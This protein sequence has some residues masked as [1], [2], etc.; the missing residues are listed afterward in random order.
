M[1][2]PLVFCFPVL[3]AVFLLAADQPK[4]PP[5]PGAVTANAVASLKNGIEVYSLMGVGTKKTWDD[6]TNKMYILRFKSGKWTEG[7]AVPGVAGRLGASAV[8]A[9]GQIFLFGGYTVDGQGNE[10]VIA[11]VNSYIPSDQRWY[12]AADI[13]VPVEGAVIGMTHDR[14]IY[15][16]GGRSKNGPVNN[17]QVYDAEKNIW[18]QATAFPGTPVFGHAGAV[19]D[20]TIVYVDGAKKDATSGK[21]VASD[22]CWMGKIDHKDPNKV[23]WSKLPPHPGPGRFG[24]VAGAGERD[25]RVLFSGGTTAPHNFKGLDADGKPEELSPMTFAFELHGNRWETI[26]EDTYDVRAD[27]RG[28]LFTPL[29]PLILGGTLKNTAIS[30]RVLAVPK[31]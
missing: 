21:Y 24:I 14:Y 20:E 12:R 25:H 6:I 26:A 13:P 31:K 18:S 28:I 17:V 3:C 9:R 22:E 27:T 5:M 11:D 8:G 16:V 23:E 30:A 1:K 15:L 2:R 10:F 19:A 4:I 7:R 29:G